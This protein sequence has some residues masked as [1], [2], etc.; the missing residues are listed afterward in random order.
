MMIFENV[1]EPIRGRA[2][3]ERIQEMRG[4]LRRRNLSNGEHNMFPDCLYVP[5]A[6]AN[7]AITLIKKSEYQV[8]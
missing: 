3:F 1:H 8:F 2:T 7:W 5:I 4:S 6:V